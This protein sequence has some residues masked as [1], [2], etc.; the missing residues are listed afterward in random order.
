[1]KNKLHNAGRQ[2]AEK[3][4]AAGDISR[5]AWTF[6][7]E[8]E[9]ALLGAD[10]DNWAAYAMWHLGINEEFPKESK[11]RYKYPFGKA[12]KIYWLALTSNKGY[13]AREEDDAIVRACS[14]LMDQI[15]GKGMNKR[16]HS[17]FTI[18]AIDSEQR[19]IE[20]IASTPTTDRMGDI[21][22]PE[23]AEFTLPIPLL[24]QHNASQPIGHVIKAVVTKAGIAITARIAKGVLP[25][26]EESWALISSGLVRGLSIGFV[27]KEF[28]EIAG[29]WGLRYTKWDW[30]E[31]SAVTIP[32]NAEASIQTIKSFDEA[33]R[34]SASGANGGAVRV[35]HFN[36]PGV[37]GAKANQLQG[38]NM[39]I[40]KQ[41]EAM[42]AKRAANAARMNDIMSKASDEGRSL[43]EAEQQEFD[44]LDGDNKQVDGHIA[45]LKTLE[46][47]MV[48]SAVPTRSTV[49]G[50][51]DPDPTTQGTAQRTSNVPHIVYGKSQLPKGTA[52]VRYAMALAASKGVRSDALD[53]ASRWKDSTPQVMNAIRFNVA[54]MV[55]RAAMTAGT[56]TDSDWAEPLV[57]YQT[58]ADEFIDLLRPQTI[59][60]KLGGLRRV[61][62]N[63]RVAGKTQGATVG[64]VGQGAPKPVSE[65]KFNEVTL[66]FAKAAG[67][68][69]VSQELARFSSPSAESVIR[70]D[71]IDTMAAFLDDQFIDPSVAAVANISPASVLNGVLSQRV[72]STGNTVALVTA[73]VRNLF[74]LF[75]A[76]DIST[77][78]GVWIMRPQDAVALQML[79]TSQDVFAFPT[80]NADGGTWFGYPV[81]T[82][83]AVPNSVSGGSIIAFI[84]PSEIF[85]AD[86]GGVRIDVSEQASL[87]MDSAPSAG[88]Q[89]LVS[90]W[91][92]NLIG[93]RAER[94]V[95]WQRRRDAA[96][97]YIDGVH[98]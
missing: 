45:R 34:R 38:S 32:A 79:R 95:N 82:S 86:D 63:I 25:Y 75:A 93:I 15:E 11:K 61:P 8:E 91:Q 20:G 30:M 18:K 81:V 41:L 74:A 59:I 2:F 94:F 23:G 24:W 55:Q 4:I 7:A 5:D 48:G 36:I 89:S 21:V 37:A 73:D 87:Q 19:L 56:T 68:V 49:G 43:D 35:V 57:E 40:Q 12:G 52:F 26:I 80:I 76:A 29:S 88:A 54:D 65:L 71:M 77:Q 14:E 9:N 16:A 13:A 83:T 96:V 28:A 78:G 51:G 50:A 33:Q 66:G 22:E 3:L 53:Y 90:L 70:T 98:Y 6:S 10:G 42:V 1:M 97:A 17:I 58:M 84:K 69:V 62:F 46:A 60:G 85:F 39:N 67:I 64:W 92:N 44:N 47:T 31:L 72:T 27:P